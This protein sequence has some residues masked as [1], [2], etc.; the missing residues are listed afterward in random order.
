M[1]LVPG[2]SMELS[3]A[4]RV[5]SSKRCS[6]WFSTRGRKFDPRVWVCEVGAWVGANQLETL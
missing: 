4:S 3:P 1:K 5:R 6:A 2:V